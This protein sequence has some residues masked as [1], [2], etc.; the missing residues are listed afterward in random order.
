MGNLDVANIITI[1]ITSVV[2]SVITATLAY[3]LGLR[4]ER[5]NRILEYSTNLLDN[6][7]EPIMRIMENSV[8]PTGGYEGVSLQAANA[9]IEIIESHSNMVEKEL[10]DL[11]W[12]L[13][14]ELHIIGD[15]GGRY[16]PF[17]NNR[18]LMDYIDLK[19]NLLRKKLN[20]HYD[21]TA[22]KKLTKK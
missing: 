12:G 17:D 10:M 11:C 20:R 6:V 4:K 18:T 19:R 16:Y 1:V 9:I 21:S 22:L 8:Y 15:N 13:K 14:E 7:Y 5:R 2:T 3:H